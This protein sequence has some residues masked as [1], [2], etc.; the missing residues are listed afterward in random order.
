MLVLSL[1]SI[2]NGYKILFVVPFPGTSHWMGLQ[3]FAKELMNRG[4]EVT[5]IVNNP[6][7]NFK[8]PKYNEIL[9]D[10]PFN[11][12]QECKSVGLYDIFSIYNINFGS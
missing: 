2:A 1:I 8:S 10:P 12:S 7:N 5:A 11:L 3:N 6:I 4:H 9:I